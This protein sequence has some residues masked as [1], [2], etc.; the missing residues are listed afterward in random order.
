M[1]QDIRAGAPQI[2]GALWLLV[3]KSGFASRTDPA[4]LAPL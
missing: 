3:F 2:S 1:G 4:R